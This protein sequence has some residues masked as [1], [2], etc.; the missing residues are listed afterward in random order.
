[1]NLIELLTGVKAKLIAWGVA[2][3]GVAALI[4]AIYRS[5]E[6]AQKVADQRRELDA[7][8]KAKGIENEVDSLPDDALRRRADRWVR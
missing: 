3:L 2:A 6:N 1:M 4:A 5:G 7:V 8:T